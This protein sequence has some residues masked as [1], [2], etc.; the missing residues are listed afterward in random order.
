METEYFNTFIIPTIGRPVLERAIKSA[1]DQH[2][3]TLVVVVFDN[4]EIF[5]PIKNKNVVYLK[6][7]KH[8]WAVGARNKGYDWLI[9]NK[10]KTKWISFLD[11]DDYVDK[12]WT[13]SLEE[14]KDYDVIVHSMKI[15][16]TGRI[17][18]TEGY[19]TKPNTSHENKLNMGLKRP[20]RN[21]V[22]CTC[23]YRFNKYKEKS[24]RW[25]SGIPTCDFTIVDDCINSGMSH[26]KTGR[27][28]YHQKLRGLTGFHT[29]RKFGPHD[30]WKKNK[31]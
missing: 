6:T 22:G 11:D 29:K 25:K 20:I 12:T 16:E 5:E 4:E 7:D 2:R 23:S 17:V 26:I 19:H 9:E 14:F 28:S 30:K 3:K 15:H 24:I 31:K 1:L 18:P 13:K 21:Y 8:V 10:V 27:I